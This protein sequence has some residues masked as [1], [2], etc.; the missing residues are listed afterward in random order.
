M[1]GEEGTDV[2]VKKRKAGGAEM[3]RIGCEIELAADDAG[4]K[5]HRAISA[6]A[7]ALQDGAQVSQKEDRN[8]GVGGQGLLQSKVSR[9]G[10]EVAR[11]QKL[12]QSAAAVKDVRTGLDALNRV[13]DQIQMVELRSQRIEE[14]GGHAASGASQ[15]G[16]ELSQGD[17]R[18]SELAAGTAAQDDLLDRVTGYFRVGQ[19]LQLDDR[20]GK[21]RKMSERSS[22]APPG[23]FYRRVQRGSRMDFAHDGIVNLAAREWNGFESERGDGGRG[24]C[25]KLGGAAQGDKRKNYLALGIHVEQA[26]HGVVYESADYLGGQA[27][28]SAD[29]Q[30]I[31]QQ[32]AV[33]PAEVAVGAVLILPGVA[34]VGGGADDCQ[35]SVGDGR[36]GGRGIDQDAAIVTGPQPAQAEL[37][38]GE[39]I[40]AGLKVRKISADQVEFD[41]VER[42]SAGGGAKVNFTAGIFSVPGDASR[43]VEQLGDGFE[44]R[45]GSGLR[46][47]DFGDGGK[48][49]D[50][51]LSDFG[52]QGR[53]LRVG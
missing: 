1:R 18:T 44:V 13:D 17:W 45:G 42:S 2:V 40:D 21:R 35:R 53:R 50:S 30:E 34:P 36:L 41:L 16:R 47:N 27:E 43:E 10:A 48:D 52:G 19:R 23:N 31:G 14:I 5:L 28:R 32:G 24:R 26:I 15:H 39:V 12:E 33:V 4:F 51:G 25:R 29:G 46:R 20:T 7:V 8:C 37:G 11:L 3:L 6:I 22:T 38:G 49:S 9:L